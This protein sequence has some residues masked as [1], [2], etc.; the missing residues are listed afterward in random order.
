MERMLAQL[1]SVNHGRPLVEQTC[2]ASQ[3]PGLALTPL[4]QQ[5]DVVTGEEGAL[6]L[7]DDRGVESVNARPWIAPVRERRQEVLAQF[8]AQ[9]PIGVTRRAQL[10]RR[11]DRRWR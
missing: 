10:T 9:R 4:A 1:G 11:G 6:Q 7:R 8:D 2:E 5:N 3:Q